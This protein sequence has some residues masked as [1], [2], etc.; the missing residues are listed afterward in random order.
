MFNIGIIGSDNS[1]AMQFSKLVNIPEGKSG[2]YNFPDMRVKYIYGHDR[3]RTEEVA[4]GGQIESIA[5]K[6]EDMIGKV[7]AV[8]VV[9]RDGGLHAQYALPFIQAGIP[10][11]IDKPFTIKIEEAKKLL[12]AAEKHN[13]LITGGSTCKYAY[14]VLL[15][16]NAVETKAVTGNIISGA[17]NFPADLESEYGGIFFYGAHMAEML[18]TIFGYDVKSVVSSVNN[19][20]VITIAKYDRYQVV[21]NF[22]KNSPR[23]LGIIYGE[24]D[25]IVREIE[26]T[27]LYHLGFKEFAEMLRSGKRP[28]SFEQLLSPVMLLNAIDK[29]IKEGCEVYI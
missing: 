14:D 7:D 11:W 18:L 16:K 6:P 23:Y 10:V 5:G 2:E 12:E 25:N 27:F 20:N 15:L 8:M 21:M 1:H 3:M 19:G 4:A 22:T 24:K 29:S 9:F 28:L 17:L 26:K 13:T